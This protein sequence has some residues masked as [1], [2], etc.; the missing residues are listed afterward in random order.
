VNRI[1]SA[2]RTASARKLPRAELSA[3][4]VARL[5]SLSAPPES[6]AAARRIAEPG[7]VVVVAG[8]QPVLFGGPALVWA[9]AWDAIELAASIHR[10]RGVPATAVFWNAS[11]DHDHAEAD[12][13]RMDLG[14]EPEAVR[15]PLP[16]DRRMLSRVPVPAEAATL[17]VSLRER[18]PQ[19]PRREEMLAALEPAA[20]DTMG[21]W[22][23]RIMLRLLGWR[24]LVVVEPETLRPFA[25][26]VVEFEISRPGELAATIRRAEAEAAMRGDPEALGLARD[27][28]FFLV[29]DAGRRL[30]VTRDGEAWKVEDGRVLTTA[31]MRALPP[32]A[33]SW[34][35]ATRVLAQDTA[36]PVAVQICGPSEFRYC[37]RLAKVH[38]ALGVPAPLLARRSQW[39]FVT[40]RSARLA[41]DLGVS[42]AVVAEPGTKRPIPPRP[43][44]E[45]REVKALRD[46]VARLTDGG[47]AAVQRRRAALLHGVDAYA[48]ALRKDEDERTAVA[49]SRRTRL[50]AMLRPDG[51]SQDRVFSPL[52]WL[53]QI[54]W[55]DIERLIASSADFRRR[56]V[57]GTGRLFE[58]GVGAVAGIEASA[59]EKDR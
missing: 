45:P 58:F 49:A 18:F 8:Q 54:E 52:P 36:L 28:L 44:V 25:A 55:T 56:R 24:G 9:K 17:I 47:S 30:R 19:G 1:D 16:A 33:F 2:V 14:A 3:A 26:S 38:A 42:T 20:G 57:A 5:E 13:V 23:S 6:V 12:H 35:V 31:Q 32:S 59:G 40:P 22:F 7:S 43:R 34:N 27:E 29:D 39:W 10:D 46:A 4:I 48:E 37:G 41:R 53:A 15:V 21:S 51:G 11:E 50:D